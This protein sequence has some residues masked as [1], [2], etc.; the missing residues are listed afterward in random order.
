MVPYP[1]D[2]QGALDEVQDF[3]IEVMWTTCRECDSA[4][5]RDFNVH[6]GFKQ[7]ASAKGRRSNHRFLASPAQKKSALLSPAWVVGKSSARLMGFHWISVTNQA[8]CLPLGAFPANL[9]IW[10]SLN[11]NDLGVDC[12]KLRGNLQMDPFPIREVLVMA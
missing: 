6:R 7:W 8:G 9:I 2:I 10:S 11:K 1:K 5:M 12:S 4:L 3:I